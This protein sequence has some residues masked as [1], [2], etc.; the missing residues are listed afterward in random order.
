MCRNKKERK[1]PTRCRYRHLAALKIKEQIEIHRQRLA[2]A[3]RAIGLYEAK[4]AEEQ[5]TI[6]L[7]E[8]D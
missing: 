5:Q 8:F 6:L 3:H 1:M 7:L 4:I 2:E